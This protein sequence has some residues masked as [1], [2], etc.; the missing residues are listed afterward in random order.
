MTTRPR[1][2]WR[3]W[4]ALLLATGA[5][6]LGTAPAAS[7]AGTCQARA[8][9]IT[10]YQGRP[11]ATRYYCS[12]YVG[13]AVYANPFDT[14][15]LDDSGYVNAA[16]EVWVIC[17]KQGRANP[18]ISGNTNANTWWLYTQGDAPRAN[19]Y[20][21][22]QG[23]GYLP[24]NAV[25]QGAQNAQVPGVPV[26]QFPAPT[27]PPLPPPPPGPPC[28]DCD[29]DGSLKI[30]DC[31]D[32]NPAVHPGAADIP[33]NPVDEDCA[34]GPAGYEPLDTTV[35][36]T[37]A[38]S[39][40]RTVFTQLLVRKVEAGSTVRTTCRGLGCPFASKTRKVAVASRRLNIAG[41]M[42]RAKLGRGARLEVRVTKAGSIG[43][44]RRLTVRAARRPPAS[45]E[46]CL[47]PGAP[48][49]VRCEL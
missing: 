39:G 32:A 20:G 8:E 24:A 13:S 44:L 15:L 33:G 23:W 30:V 25:S 16:A 4:A 27:T 18:A 7:A 46:L 36:Y 14:S 3:L 19:A 22:T 43:V 17:Q 42:R 41:P 1:T 31:D 35:S 26:C 9:S 11:F 29:G 28:T 49:P 21:Y 12:T 47:P 40:R 34:G 10:D 48:R 45:A 37:Y 5:A 38:F 6:A 2:D